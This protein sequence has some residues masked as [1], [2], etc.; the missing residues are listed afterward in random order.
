[1]LSV[2]VRPITVSGRAIPGGVSADIFLFFLFHHSTTGL[3]DICHVTSR[4]SHAACASRYVTRDTPLWVSCH[5]TCTH[6]RHV[7]FQASK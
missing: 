3:R 6:G 2:R 7:E 5:V 4:D 1:M